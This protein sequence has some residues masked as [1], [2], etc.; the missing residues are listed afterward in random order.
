MWVPIKVLGKP[1]GKSCCWLIWEVVCP[2]GIAEVWNLEVRRRALGRVA[3]GRQR[4]LFW[5]LHSTATLAVT[6][7]GAGSFV[8]NS[9]VPFFISFFLP[10]LVSLLC[11]KGTAFWESVNLS[12]LYFGRLFDVN[13][14]LYYITV[15]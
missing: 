5:V 8:F 9:L 10:C 7:P 6:E 1:P 14:I 11:G 12:F 3:R 4:L 13:I 15:T 2:T